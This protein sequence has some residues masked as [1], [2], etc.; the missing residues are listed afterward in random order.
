[1]GSRASDFIVTSLTHPHPTLP[2]TLTSVLCQPHHTHHILCGESSRPV[3]AKMHATA[4]DT[5]PERAH[6]RKARMGSSLLRG[7]I[8]T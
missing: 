4:P 2:L 7:R 6:L 5:H 1:M 8:Q 3:V